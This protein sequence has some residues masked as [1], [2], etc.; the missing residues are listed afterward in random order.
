MI[1]KTT[2]VHNIC[3]ALKTNKT[4]VF[5]LYAFKILKKKFS[6]VIP[7]NNDNDN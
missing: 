5:T 4:N 7:I 1:T 6:Y 3:K 2:D